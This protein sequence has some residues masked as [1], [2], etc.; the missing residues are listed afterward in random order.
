ML[1][2]AIPHVSFAW[3]SQMFSECCKQKIWSV[4]KRCQ[5]NRDGIQSDYIQLFTINFVLFSVN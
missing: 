5:S 3:Q 2:W 4:L 1:L